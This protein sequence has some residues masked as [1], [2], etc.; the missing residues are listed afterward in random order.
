ML[1]MK[2]SLMFVIFG[3]AAYNAYA[4]DD[5]FMRL[6]AITS[7]LWA[8]VKKSVEVDQAKLAADVAKIVGCSES[9]ITIGSD[10]DLAHLATLRGVIGSLPTATINLWKKNE[11]APTKRYGKLLGYLEFS[12]LWA[13]RDEDRNWHVSQRMKVDYI[14]TTFAPSN[15]Q[16]PLE[17][18]LSDFFIKSIAPR[19]DEDSLDMQARRI[20]METH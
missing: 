2:K 20:Y 16:R 14:E 3:C 11:E 1:F 4:L 13:H 8:D 12:P 6:E 7:K 9:D 17:N 19:F 15:I 5:S 18:A 10:P